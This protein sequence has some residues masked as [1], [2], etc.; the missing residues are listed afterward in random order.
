MNERKG[1]STGPSI[2]ISGLRTW[3]TDFC[4]FS[5]MYEVRTDGARLECIFRVGGGREIREDAG[6]G[7]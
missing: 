6:P 2:P 1:Y 7:V 3:Y 5:E 4:A